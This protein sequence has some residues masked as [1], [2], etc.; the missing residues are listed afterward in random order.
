MK[1]DYVALGFALAFRRIMAWLD[2][3]AA[4][5]DEQGRN[6]A[7]MLAFGAGKFVQFTFPA[8]YAW[9]FEPERLR[10]TAPTRRGLRRALAFGFGVGAAMI[11]V[12]F[13]WLKHGS[14]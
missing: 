10:P 13:A 11:I 9:W 7:L 2:F 8:F 3:V 4:A 1:R 6:V 12:Y 5:G 14:A